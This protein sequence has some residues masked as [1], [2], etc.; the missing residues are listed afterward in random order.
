MDRKELINEN[1]C[2]LIKFHGFNVT[3]YPSNILDMIMAT[4]VL[5]ANLLNFQKAKRVL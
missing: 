2:N 1:F 4:A 3:T 5:I